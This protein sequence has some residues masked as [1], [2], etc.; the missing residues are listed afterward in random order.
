MTPSRPLLVA[1]LAAAVSV[2][3]PIPAV[4][5]N[6]LTCTVTRIV[7]A[8]TFY[9][10]SQ[11]RIRLLLIDA[12]EHDQLPYGPAATAALERLLPPGSTASLTLDV[13]PRDRY[14]RILAYVTNARH[15]FVN[16]EMAREGYAMAVI[17]PPNVR[18]VD[19]VRAASAEAQSERRGLWATT[20][21]S[22]TPANH[23]HG[24]C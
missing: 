11:G 4:A 24:R 8:D 12:P 22:C 18:Y 7:D 16:V 17:F 5:Q 9:C 6:H 10:G 23:R 21:F 20:A 15:V 14:G 19:Q 3:A 13:V 1:A 2:A